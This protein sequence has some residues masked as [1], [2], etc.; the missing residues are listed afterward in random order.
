MAARGRWRPTALASGR[1]DYR[2]LEAAG[3]RIEPFRRLARLRVY[4]HLAEH[5]PANEPFAARSAD[6]LKSMDEAASA[7]RKQRH[8]ASLPFR[9]EL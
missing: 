5:S 6:S 3:V 4:R 8:A 7:G 1:R 2:R 9:N